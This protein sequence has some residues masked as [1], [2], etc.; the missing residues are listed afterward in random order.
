MSCSPAPHPDALSIRVDLAAGRVT[1]TGDLDRGSAHHL[2][3]AIAALVPTRHARWELD[4]CGVTWCDA[5]GLRALLS[6]TTLAARLDRE[7]AVVAA[8]R[9]VARLLAL[10]EP[11]PGRPPLWPAPL[12][13]A[14]A[15]PARRTAPE[16]CA[17]PA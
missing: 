4:A 3:D 7:L 10:V 8:S 1:L 9:C 14:Q 6:A 17:T 12:R 16:R 13:A 11:P 5:G 15:R 2:T